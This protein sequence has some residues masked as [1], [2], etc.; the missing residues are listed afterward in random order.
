MDDSY[1]LHIHHTLVY[2]QL[3]IETDFRVFR[4][5]LDELRWWK[6]KPTDHK[7]WLIFFSHH[8]SFIWLLYHSRVQFFDFLFSPAHRHPHFHRKCIM[9]RICV[10]ALP[11]TPPSLNYVMI[12]VCSTGTC[13]R[14]RRRWEWICTFDDEHLWISHVSHT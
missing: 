7:A 2:V 8:R 14:D 9:F 3:C 12:S 10:Y 5:E 11:T 13:E 4:F 1:I 6:S